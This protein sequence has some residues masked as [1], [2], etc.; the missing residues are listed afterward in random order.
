MPGPS[1]AFLLPLVIAG[2]AYPPRLAVAAIIA[3]TVASIGLSVQ[4]AASLLKL[5]AGDIVVLVIITAVQLLLVGFGALGFAW[6]VRT[7]AELR[8]AREQLALL[9]VEQERSRFARDVEVEREV[10]AATDRGATI[11]E[12]AGTLFFSEGTVRNH[13][14]AAI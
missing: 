10:L 7:I 4:P 6:L 14:S 8:K 3:L 5:T 13:L 9:A 2:Y 12:I 11:P 1:T